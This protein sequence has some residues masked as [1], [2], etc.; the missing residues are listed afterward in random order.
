MSKTETIAEQ[1]GLGDKYKKKDK[2]KKK[3]EQ[4]ILKYFKKKITEAIS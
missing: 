1:I 3:E 4:G 2:K